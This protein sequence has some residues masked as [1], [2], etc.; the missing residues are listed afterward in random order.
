MNKSILTVLILVF[1]LF[2]AIGT[3]YAFAQGAPLP[4]CGSIPV[5]QTILQWPHCTMYVL[6]QLITALI[7]GALIFGSLLLLFNLFRSAMDYITAG[8]DTDK[9]KQARMNIT[10]ST[11]GLFGVASIFILFDYLYDLI[12]GLDSLL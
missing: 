5:G 6:G 11:I 7:N 9:L 8:D 12:P 3:D 4:D 2:P 10:W 1:V